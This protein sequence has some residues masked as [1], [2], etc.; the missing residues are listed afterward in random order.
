L[1]EIGF[2][3]FAVILK[4]T[5]AIFLLTVFMIQQSFQ[6]AL[7][8]T[9]A[10]N[11]TEI[12]NTSCV[13]SM[14]ADNDCKGLCVLKSKLNAIEN[15]QNDRQNQQGNKSLLPIEIVF[16]FNLNLFDNESLPT[17]IE[18][19][20]FLTFH[21]HSNYNYLFSAKIYSPPRNQHS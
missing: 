5:F 17:T 19:D 8:L 21:H 11:R 10:W 7:I 1:N 14:I 9:W 6:A 12:A 2:Y 13:K 4:S 18:S 3:K 15:P 20:E 16:S